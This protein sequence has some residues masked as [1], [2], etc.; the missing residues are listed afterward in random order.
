MKAVSVC[1]PTCNGE[2]FL[3]KQ[4]DSIFSQLQ[5]DDEIVVSDDNSSDKTLHILKSYGDRRMKI[6]TNSKRVGVKKNLQIALKKSNNEVIVLADQDDIWLDNKLSVIRSCFEYSQ[7]DKAMTVLLNGLIIN[8]EEA[9]Q[10]KTLFELHKSRR[11]ILKN[12]YRNSYMGCCLAFNRKV[13]DYV[14]DFPDSIPMHDVW[15]GIVSEIFGEVKLITENTILYRIHND[16]QS[17]KKVNFFQRVHWRLCLVYA[18]IR[19]IFSIVIL[20]EKRVCIVLS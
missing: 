12:I 4:L 7:P 17:L 6:S 13:M 3:K 8:E 11:G 14:L 15:I 1:I 20:G 5:E 19:R 18:L 9:V 2:R 16:N 10:E